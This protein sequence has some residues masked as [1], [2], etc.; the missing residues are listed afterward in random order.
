M[1]SVEWTN[2]AE[3]EAYTC[4]RAGC[5][6][7]LS[8]ILKTV[9]NNPYDPSQHFER[10]TGNLKG[11]CS[12]EINHHNRFVYKVLPNDEDARNDAG[13]LYDGIVLVFESWGHKYK[14]PK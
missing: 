12:R 14:N 5:K 1:Y 3:K 2:R 4:I 9:E 7:R 13:E 11:F 10:L 6:E 8:E